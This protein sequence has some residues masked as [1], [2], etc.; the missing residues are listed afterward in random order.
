MSDELIRQSIIDEEH[1]KL[2]SLGYLISAATTAFFSIFALMYVGMGLFMGTLISHQSG[3][4]TGADQ[5]PP[6]FIGWFV[7]AAGLGGFLFMIVL[8]AAKFRTAICLKNR[9][10]RTFCMI[11]AGIS[12]LGI[13]FGTALGVFTFVVLGRNSVALL[14]NPTVRPE[15]L[16]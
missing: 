8:A 11:V 2:L 14:F 3:V 13:P 7:A 10:S 15:S 1:L 5:V 4:S 12:C 6:A 16:T 9:R